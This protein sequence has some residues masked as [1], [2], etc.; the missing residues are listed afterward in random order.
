VFCDQ[1]VFSPLR[2]W[3]LLRG[4]FRFIFFMY[5]IYLYL[6]STDCLFFSVFFSFS[7]RCAR[8]VRGVLVRFSWWCSFDIFFG[9]LSV[10][11]LSIFFRLFF[12]PSF[13]GLTRSA[14]CLVNTFYLFFF[15]SFRVGLEFRF[16]LFFVVSYFSCFF[17][18][19]TQC[20]FLSFYG[21]IFHSFFFITSL[22]AISVRLVAFG[23]S[24]GLLA[25]LCSGH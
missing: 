25:L 9:A 1:W 20:C 2:C 12:C 15:P 6:F 23:L 22:F 3:C 18:G 5:G 7:R 24:S 16:C 21:L 10:R 13:L 19:P 8:L 14:T 17:V 4:G 11:L